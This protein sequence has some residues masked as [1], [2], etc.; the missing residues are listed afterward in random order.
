MKRKGLRKRV[1]LAVTLLV[2]S[3]LTVLGLALSGLNFMTQKNQLM[4]LQQE[5]VKGAANEIKWDIHEIE[6]LLRVITAYNDLVNLDRRKQFNALSQI[7]THQD[8]KLHNFVDELVL[9][10]SSGRE[11]TR[12]SRS[13]V[14]SPSELSERSEADEFLVPV[15][16]GEIYYGPVTFDEKSYEPRIMLSLPVLNVRS[17]TVE[18]VLLAR[19]RLNRTWEN[20]SSISFGES[21]TVFITDVDGKV[22]AHP[23]PSVIY[24]NTYFKAETPKG[25]QPG[26]NDEKIMLVSEGFQ[27]GDHV[28]TVYA[29]LPFREVLALS[30]RTLS[31]TAFFLLVFIGLSIAVSFIVIR[32][33][34]R[35]IELLADTA[36]N[37]SAGN[38]GLTARVEDS[39]EIGDL[40]EAFNIMS[41][42]LSEMIKS[43]ESQMYELKKAEEKIKQQN[44]FLNNVLS[45]LTHPFYIIDVNNYKV[46]MANPAAEFGKLS[47]ESTCYALT[48]KRDKPC[49]DIEHPCVIKKIK[50]VGKPVTV[51]HIHY[52]GEGNPLINEI[53]GYPIFDDGG[54]ITYVI[55]YNIDIT[56]RKKAEE[57]I[58]NSL[59]EKE[60]LL[61]EIHHRTKNNM[62]IISSLLRLQS[63]QLTDKKSAAI[64]Q[65]SQNRIQSMS[66]IHEQLYESKDLTRVDFGHY[67][68]DL[69]QGLIRLC[70]T[71]TGNIRVEQDIKDI[72]L[73]I[74]TAIPCG[75]I[76]NELVTNS[77]KYAFPE[78]R[79]GTIRINLNRTD[80]DEIELILSD[81]GIGIPDD[82]D[83]KHTK[84]LGLQLVT[85]L[86][87]HQLQGRIEL[88]R[89]KGTEFRITFRELKYE[90]RV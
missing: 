22:L 49:E 41:S 62:Q 50:E 4:A 40:S 32:R 42:K 54:N 33:V 81:N 56:S 13:V 82:L 1:A 86:S 83:I 35:P 87:E 77:L 38:L 15:R 26:L 39:D 68:G 85:T 52:D 53:H 20:V 6:T 63:A 43:L 61:R 58:R 71:R 79:E 17:W 2:V 74:D 36:K 76:I 23:D 31:T 75:L 47:G 21:G 70:G 90:E 30:F 10:D 84:T 34:V 48:H 12:V 25:I 14:Y 66:L 16:S 45:S 5:V 73:G 89:T 72:Y 65:D 69:T 7:L 78:G 51:E 59:R 46:K 28:F 29:A 64:L 18:S 60:V 9:L 27:L 57:G 37:I 88:D 19:I 67:I 55:E 24:R 11:L 3:S 8:I 44:E 80:E